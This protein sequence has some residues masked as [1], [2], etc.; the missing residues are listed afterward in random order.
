MYQIKCDNYILY[1]PRDEELIV[2]NPKCKL[3]VNTVGEASFTIYESHPF[4]AYLKKLKSIFEILQ[5]GDVIFR[6]RMTEDSKDFDNIKVVDL[7]GAMAYFNDSVIRPFVF[8]DDI[9]SNSGYIEAAASGNVVEYFL[10]W[11]IN[12]HNSQV[13]DFQQFK[14]GTVTV[15]DPNNYLSRSAEDYA[16]TWETLKSKLF[17]SALGGYLCIRYEDDGN[18]IDYLADF[19]LT[20]IQRV[21]FGENLL[22]ISTDSDASAT[23][24]AIIPLGKKLN[25]IA[26][27]SGNENGTTATDDKSRLTIVAEPNGEINEDIVKDGDT[28][29]S[30][31]AV[32]EYGFIYAPTKD[33]TWNDITRASNLV[34]QG[35]EYLVTTA[36]KLTNTIKITALDLH[37]SDE[38]IEA[39]RI[40]RYIYVNSKPHEHEGRYKLTQLDIDILNPQ[41]TKITLGDTTKSLTDINSGNKQTVEE[42]IASIQT[43]TQEQSIDLSEVAN[44]AL[45][46][47]TAAISTSEAIIFSALKSYVET[48]NYESFTET[49]Q[50]QLK[51]MSENIT[52]NFTSLTD[53]IKNVDGDLQEKF[54]QITKY[55]S[56]DIN[57]LTIG[58][59]DNPY[60]VVIDN[61]RYS[62]LVN[63]VEVLWLDAEGKAHIPEIDV[64]RKMTLLGYLI[65]EDE[66]GNLNCEYVGG[67]S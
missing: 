27:E 40:Y 25:E 57:G 9:K 38:E 8:P 34:D 2:T 22:D 42:Q 11:L 29:F 46:Q 44:T 43:Q 66:N 58:Q 47:A 1:D 65:N 17:D 14:L 31:S 6:G 32:A 41:N 61:D 26:K 50:S 45:E 16:T 56:F 60:K 15:S 54:N 52:L 36:M 23:Y 64:S 13:Q 67:E 12:Q 28:L 33:T 51:V 48:S 7:E 24:S 49:I 10:E 18:Y 53:Q 59:T 35:V 37:Y 4:Y 5:D 62:M 30:K 19:D 20:N 21:E 3:Q 55:F 39:F 63:G